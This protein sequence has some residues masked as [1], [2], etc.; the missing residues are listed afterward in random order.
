MYFFILNLVSIISAITQECYLSFRS[1][2][3]RNMSKESKPIGLL[4]KHL[5]GGL[6][7]PFLKMVQHLSQNL[8]AKKAPSPHE[9]RLFHCK[10]ATTR[11]CKRALMSALSRK[12]RK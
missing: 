5:T 6:A 3:I 9:G 8:L 10:T 1:Q 12:P 7:C 2:R 4:T 11:S